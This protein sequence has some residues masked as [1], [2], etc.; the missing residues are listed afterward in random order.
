MT[1]L[2]MAQGGFEIGDLVVFVF[3]ALGFLGWLVSQ[4]A[5]RQAGQGR[6]PPGDP[7]RQVPQPARRGEA[8]RPAAP[9]PAGDP[10]NEVEDFLRRVAERRAG[11]KPQEVEVL[12]PQPPSPPRPRPRPAVPVE[13]EV[14]EVKKAKTRS[15]VFRGSSVSEHVDVHLGEDDVGDR[16]RLSKAGMSSS[17]DMSDDVMDEHIHDVFDHQLGQFK[18][19]TTSSATGGEAAKPSAGQTGRPQP[20]GELP[21]TAAAGL[22]ALLADTHSL[23]RAIVINEILKRPEHDW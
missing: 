18:R 9:R 14:V 2:L 15:P 7:R 5:R 8:P 19:S 17:P 1:R 12:E 4:I 21:Q 10:R 20:R 23:R 16:R 13:A 3:L 11:A 22:A 6:Q